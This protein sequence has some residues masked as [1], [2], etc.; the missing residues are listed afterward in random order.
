[1]ILAIN[2]STL[3]FSISLSAM[4]GTLLAE[5]I[6][7]A[8]HRN[9]GSLSTTFDFLLESSRKNLADIRAVAVAMGP[10][11]FT[12][13]RVGL[14]MAK[15]ICHGLHLPL[16]GISTL[17]ALANQIPYSDL[18][19]TP[20]VDSRKGEVFVARFTWD[21][22]SGSMRRVM[23]DRCV[24][25]EALPQICSEP[26]VLIGNDLEKQAPLLRKVIT[27]NIFYAPEDKW[28]VRASAIGQLGLKHYRRGKEDSLESLSPKYF[29][30]PDIRPNPYPLLERNEGNEIKS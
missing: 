17:E 30:S 6:A 4:N 19:I 25:L 22:P 14:S 5:C 23:E 13:L 12:G 8:P 20:I 2:T 16:I 29:R 10:G 15:G 18:P 7:S 21:R 9:F 28:H 26:T 11:S 3:Q 1:M 24:K 27:D